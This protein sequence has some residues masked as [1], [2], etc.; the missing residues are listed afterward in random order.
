MRLLL[1]HNEL[2]F[3]P[4]LEE[5]ASSVLGVFTGMYDWA[6]TLEIID[7]EVFPIMELPAAPLPIGSTSV[8]ALW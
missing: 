1:R 7:P 4:S 8:C 2:V 6:A 5:L 3:E